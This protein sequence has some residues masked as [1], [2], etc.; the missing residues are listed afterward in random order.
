MIAGTLPVESAQAGK[1]D[2]LDLMRA[3][4]RLGMAFTLNPATSPVDLE[5]TIAR[6]ALFAPR[7]ERLFVMAATWLAAR[8]VLV[9][10][11]RLIVAVQPLDPRAL[12]VAGALFSL[13]AEA[14]TGRTAL[15][16]AI[17]HCRPLRRPV[18][19]FDVLNRHKALLSVVKRETP[20]LYR[21]WGL[22]HNDTRLAFDALRPVRWTL[23]HCPE[24]RFRA[25]LGSGLDARIAAAL[26]EDPATITRLSKSTEATY[27]ATYAAATRLAGRGLVQPP[28]QHAQP[29]EWR[30]SPSLVSAAEAA[31][32]AT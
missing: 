17:E 3:W 8:H 6:T 28:D 31:F 24:L 14:T 10:A 13:A 22:W 23:R 20:P 7:S 30:V 32:A 9:D 16:A 1:D 2:E 5:P 19:L 26:A 21:R 4:T 27:A 15:H 18:P 25:L 12:A 29:K 11:R